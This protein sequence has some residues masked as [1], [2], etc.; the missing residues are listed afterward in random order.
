MAK[1][2]EHFL[3]EAEVKVGGTLLKGDFAIASV[4]IHHEINKIPTATI[5]IPD[6]NPAT[7]DFPL[8]ASGS[9]ELKPGKPVTISFSSKTGSEKYDLF[10][11]ILVKHGIRLRNGRSELILEAKDKAVKMTIGERSR[12]FSEKK[13]S[14][15]ISALIQ[16]AGASA[17][18]A[19]TT[20]KHKAFMQHHCSDWD[21]MLMRAEAMGMIVN[22]KANKVSVQKPKFSEKKELVLKYGDNLL[23]IDLEIDARTQL[24]AVKATSWSLS[25]SKLVE[26]TKKEPGTSVPDTP[27]TW[28]GKALGKELGPSEVNQIHR[29]AVEKDV[30]DAWAEA[31]MLKSRMARVQGLIKTHG[32][33]I[34]PGKTIS[35]KGVGKSLEGD[36]F[37]T[38]VK[39]TLDQ[40]LWNT[41]VKIGLSPE[42]HHQRFGSGA[43]GGSG[44]FN[45][46]Q[47]LQP[48][49]VTKIDADPDSQHRVEIDLNF[50]EGAGPAKVWARM[51]FPDAGKKRGLFWLPEVGDEVLV[52]FMEGDPAFPVILG[53]MYSSKAGPPVTADKKNPEKG[54][55]TASGIKMVFNDDKKTLHIETP[56]GQK[57]DLDDDKKAITLEDSNGNKLQMD[58]DGI[59]LNSSKDI[60]L[61]A[62]SSGKIKGTGG[63]G[64]IAFETSN[65]DFKANGLNVK[66]DAKMEF[67]GKGKTGATL[68]SS[69]LTTVKGTL[70]KI[71]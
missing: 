18:V 35:L 48:A 53:S 14:E 5:I 47:G 43:T 55:Y 70:V 6:G 27:G 69:T 31:R 28:T 16:E 39:H 66:C 58:K 37:V 61:K 62:A 26:S 41:T 8:S 60:I 67:S 12:F 17:D 7:Q 64:G 54:I 51:A 59:T 63:S 2:G 44:Y 30:L 22:C 29:G 49:K 13:D 36:I 4:S 52:G 57:F 50:W 40:G 1:I 24:Q 9:P 23:E 46:V 45:A 56:G 19:A 3:I 42:W 20:Y 38:G 15:I 11:G 34:D 71:N 68:E 33:E 32:F 21:F 10:E 25:D 65:G